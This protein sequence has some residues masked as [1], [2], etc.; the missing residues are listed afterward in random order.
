MRRITASVLGVLFLLSVCCFSAFAQAQSTAADYTYPPQE[1]LLID[2][3]IQPYRYLSMTHSTQ[4]RKHPAVVSINGGPAQRIAVR[5]R[6]AMSLDDGMNFASKRI[7]MELL[8][9]DSDPDGKFQG[10]ASLKLINCYTPAKLL[11]QLIAMQT[12]RYLGIPTPRMQPA[13]VRINDVDFGL[14]LALEDLNEDFVRQHFGS[15]TL[16][17]RFNMREQ[18][19]GEEA[20]ADSGVTLENVKM[21][22]KADHGV[23][24]LQ[25]Y[26]RS[27]ARGESILPYL[28]ADELLRFLACEMFVFDQDGIQY[29]KNCYFAE[30]DGKLS[31]LPW[32]QSVVFNVFQTDR[33]DDETFLY[34]EQQYRV[35][36]VMYDQL[37]RNEE[38]VARY[39]QYIRQLND[40]FLNP[41]T[42]LPWLEQYIRFLSPYFQRDNSIGLRSAHMAQDLMSGTNLYD[43]MSGNL[44]LTFRVYHDQTD[45]ILSGKAD[46]YSIPDGMSAGAEDPETEADEMRVYGTDHSIVY[47]ICSNYWKKC[48]Q[49]Y[50]QEN[51]SA[52]GKTGAA[53]AAVFL[54][55][56]LS[57]KMPKGK[58]P[59]GSPR[60]KEGEP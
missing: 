9:D 6:G 10:N 54:L 46:W 57:V 4:R 27:R 12:F 44:L 39:R 17:R 5:V 50:Y 18:I 1:V 24:T 43:D 60:E 19:S 42:F 59:R 41:D 14:Y 8:F 23:Q 28:D 26:E 29:L 55:T 56:V 37:L 16:Y 22:V 53:L 33:R 25:M 32:D 36:T 48:R 7:P 35:G 30:H 34:Y 51:A 49:A 47:R 52:I 20:A 45:A 31:A 3:V 2:L 13:F 58:K 38:S 11:T 21:K 15:A 40:G